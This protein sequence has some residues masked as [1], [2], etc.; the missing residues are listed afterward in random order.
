[1]IGRFDWD[2]KGTGEWKRDGVNLRKMWV[3]EKRP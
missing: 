1:M 2:P 3:A